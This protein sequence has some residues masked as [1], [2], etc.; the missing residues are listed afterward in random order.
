MNQNTS[1]TNSVDGANNEGQGGNPAEN[2]LRKVEGMADFDPATLK[3]AKVGLHTLGGGELTA[4]SLEDML[5]FPL[6]YT[7]K[8]IGFNTPEFVPAVETFFAE[9][10]PKIH[11]K[12]SSSGKYVSLS[13]T[14]HLT[15]YATLKKYYDGVATLKGFKYCM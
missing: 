5:E 1:N 7:Y 9:A 6:D 12:E 8:V 10:S 11:Q 13:I 4:G 15:D 3:K 2:N 14:V